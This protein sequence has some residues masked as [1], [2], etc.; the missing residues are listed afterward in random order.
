MPLNVGEG[1]GVDDV[2][3]TKEHDEAARSE[4]VAKRLFCVFYPPT[5][6]AAA[7]IDRFIVHDNIYCIQFNGLSSSKICK[8]KATC[9]AS[10]YQFTS[11]RLFL[12]K[13]Q[14]AR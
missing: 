9:R 10:Q 2:K 4:H 6:M 3:V 7:E 11:A 13:T 12:V 14:N 5:H 1:P 8:M